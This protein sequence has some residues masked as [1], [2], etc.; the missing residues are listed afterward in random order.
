MHSIVDILWCFTC[1]FRI[2]HND[3]V[4][5]SYI[6]SFPR[7]WTSGPTVVRSPQFFCR[8][9]SLRLSSIWVMYGYVAIW[10]IFTPCGAWKSP[11]EPEPHKSWVEMRMVASDT[12]WMNINAK[13]P[14]AELYRW[15][16]LAPQQ[17]PSPALTQGTE[18]SEVRLYSNFLSIE[19]TV[20]ETW[21]LKESS[22]TESDT[23]DR[24]LRYY[25]SDLDR[26][27]S[28]H[29]TRSNSPVPW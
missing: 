6:A 16:L 4:D 29:D 24:T 9:I 26:G 10:S 12:M 23:S 19:T 15:C 11:L 27:E 13:F 18:D 5:S 2:K 14:Q 8:K 25:P 20:A 22:G 17:L 1:F 3:I 28:G 7:S 21:I